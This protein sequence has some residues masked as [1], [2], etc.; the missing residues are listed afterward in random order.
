MESV[1]SNSPLAN[2]HSAYADRYN[3]A[4]HVAD[5]II[6]ALRHPL[7]LIHRSDADFF[8]LGSTGN[9]YKVTL[10]AIPSCTCPDRTV[11]CKHVLFVILR[12]LGC[13]LDDACVWRRTLR[14]CQLARI[15]S[16]PMA[17]DVLAGARARE[18]FYQL[19]SGANGTDHQTAIGRED[20]G[21]VCPICLE[22]MEGEAG[23]AT[24]GSCGNSLHEECLA[25]W[26]RSRSGRGVRCVMCRARWRKRREQELYVN[27]AAYVGEDDTVEDPG[28]SCNGEEEKKKKKNV[29]RECNDVI[30]TLQVLSVGRGKE[31]T[32]EESDSICKQKTLQMNLCPVCGSDPEWKRKREAKVGE[33]LVSFLVSTVKKLTFSREGGRVGPATD[34]PQLDHRAP[35]RADTCNAVGVPTV[36]FESR[37]DVPRPGLLQPQDFAVEASEEEIE[38]EFKGGNGKEEAAD[39]NTPTYKPCHLNAAENEVAI[40][41]AH[42][43]ALAIPKNKPLLAAP[44]AS[45][46]PPLIWMR[47]CVTQEDITEAT[48]TLADT[49]SFG[50]GHVLLH[51]TKMTKVL[52]KWSGK[53]FSEGQRNKRVTQK[54]SKWRG[55]TLPPPPGEQR[56]TTGKS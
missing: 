9:V 17:P 40:Q 46:K 31:R 13:P 10:A 5:R 27:L 54:W 4:Q 33:R 12:V 23:L 3:L 50:F 19:L 1:G 52:M 14:P 47:T 16:T 2:S 24:C 53:I 32:T 15:L 29:R 11:P 37:L 25:R 28:A 44:A 45:M 36:A 21:A 43:K 55:I 26:K 56:E 39:I 34:S 7:R 22:E 20:D 48:V 30:P 35:R 6:R 8:V 38:L 41:S 42:A 49:V 51:L 18:R